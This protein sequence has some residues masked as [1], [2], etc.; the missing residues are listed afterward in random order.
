MRHAVR[1]ALR[2]GEFGFIREHNLDVDAAAS[3]AAPGHQRSFR[4]PSLAARCRCFSYP[5][6]QNR[7]GPVTMCICRLSAVLMPNPV[8]ALTRA[9]PGI[10]GSSRRPGGANLVGRLATSR[11]AGARTTTA[12]NSGLWLLLSLSVWT[13]SVA[14]HESNSFLAKPTPSRPTG[15][16]VI[17]G[18]RLG[19]E[20][21][22]YP[23]D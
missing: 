8:L 5:V 13:A 15:V 2:V 23:A 7:L 3:L 18:V 19:P 12:L 21:V 22:A 10:C 6:K 17:S 16:M 20:R 11:A 1:V 14:R 9:M 4:Q